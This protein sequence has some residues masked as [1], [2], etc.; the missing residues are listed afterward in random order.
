[1]EDGA[2][3]TFSASLLCA[4]K[5]IRGERVLAFAQGYKALTENLF[6][7]ICKRLDEIVGFGN[8]SY[9]KGSVKIML[10]NGTG[11]I[12]GLTYENVDAC[13]GYTEIS[14]LVLDEGALAPPTIFEVA[15]PCLRGAK[16]NKQIYVTSTPK[17]GSFI[18]QFILETL[19]KDPDIIELIK[20][21]SDDNK[22]IAEDLV[23]MRKGF[24]NET[25]MRQEMEG[26]LLDLKAENSLLAN[27]TYKKGT[28]AM[29]SKGR[30]II[31]ID[32]SGWGKDQTVITYRIGNSFVQK[33]YGVLSGPDCRNEIK[34][35][36]LQNRGWSVGGIWIDA[37]Y[38]EKYYENLSME[39]ENV[40]LINFGSKPNDEQYLNKR[41][42]I[43]FDLVRA[44]RDGMPITEEIEKE[45]TFT[46]FEFTNNGKLKLISKDDIKLVLKHSP[47]KTDSLALTFA[48]GV[49]D[50]GEKYETGEDWYGNPED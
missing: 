22:F 48:Q 18:N 45:L 8:Y 12:Y 37:A 1:M 31:G 36:L 6:A 39:Y 23:L 11:V 13:R 7:E 40:D 9:N 25:I 14:S 15:Q 29:P 16:T 38:G 47:D 32:G 43:Y 30:V 3:K 2:G 42:E 4:L 34:T 28:I 27:L 26:E 35:M 17:A 20:A 19:E 44:M 49:K 10:N 50:Y 41:S 46:L 24:S 21:R 5:L 33:C